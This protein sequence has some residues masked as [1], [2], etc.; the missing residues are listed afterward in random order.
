M[1]CKEC[2]CVGAEVANKKVAD[3]IDNHNVCEPG[4]PKW[5]QTETAGE[6][7]CSRLCFAKQAVEHYRKSISEGRY[8]SKEDIEFF[9]AIMKNYE[10]E[11]RR[12]EENNADLA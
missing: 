1:R 9:E 4:F 5:F 2:G 12:I 3:T 7:Y 10:Q 8:K 11:I 6:W